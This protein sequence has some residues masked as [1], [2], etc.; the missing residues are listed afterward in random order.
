MISY[1]ENKHEVHKSHEMV[2]YGTDIVAPMGT[3]RFYG[4]KMCKKC[5]C[6]LYTHPAGDFCDEDLLTEC[7]C[8]EE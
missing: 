8:K 6:K 1:N 5:E 4:V 7:L 3:A 2:D